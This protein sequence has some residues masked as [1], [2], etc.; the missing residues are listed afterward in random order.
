MLKITLT[1]DGQVV[2]G[3]KAVG[4]VNAHDWKPHTL[5]ENLKDKRWPLIQL[6]DESRHALVAGDLVRWLAAPDA[7]LMT[8]SA[9]D[10]VI[11]TLQRPL[12]LAIHRCQETF[13]HVKLLTN[14]EN[15][16]WVTCT[17]LVFFCSY[18]M[19]VV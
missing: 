3:H 11:A 15:R 4:G 13:S 1:A 10:A 5:R 14:Y 7:K 17:L 6:D 12:G 18:C 19:Y 2:V 16:D 8:I 9:L